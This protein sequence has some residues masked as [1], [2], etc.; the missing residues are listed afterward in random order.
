[1]LCNKTKIKLGLKPGAVTVFHPKRSVAYAIFNSVDE[2]LDK[3]ERVNTISPVNFS[4]WAVPIVVVRNA[5]GTIRICGDYSTGPNDALQPHQY[6]LP[7]P[8]DIFAKL[9]NCTAKLLIVRLRLT[10]AVGIYSR[11]TLTEDCTVIIA[12]RQE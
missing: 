2:E 11:L 12:Y 5:N 3:L 8:E 6:P 7:L 4:K 1:M 9:A 10:K